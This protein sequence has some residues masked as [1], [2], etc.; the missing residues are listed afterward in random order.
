MYQGN[1]SA[2][3]TKDM[4]NAQAPAL[5]QGDLNHIQ[6]QSLLEALKNEKRLSGT[7]DINFNLAQNND[8]NGVVKVGIKNGTLEGFDIKY[9]LSLPQSL[10][11]KK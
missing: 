2:Q 6:I 1:L 3:I 11:S 7:A 8:T 5:I 9:Y 10:V 4:N